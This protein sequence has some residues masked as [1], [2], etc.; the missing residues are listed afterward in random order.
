[1]SKVIE[2]LKLEKLKKKND[3]EKDR[4]K[5]METQKRSACPGD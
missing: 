5:N 3:N 1:M 2:E 4:E